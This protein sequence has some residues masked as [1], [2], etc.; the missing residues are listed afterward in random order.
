MKPEYQDNIHKYQDNIHRDLV[1]IG[2]YDRMIG[3][4]FGQIRIAL[5]IRGG[6][7]GQY[8]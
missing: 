6:I 5:M 7:P 2:Q 8:A 1:N 3:Q 4:I